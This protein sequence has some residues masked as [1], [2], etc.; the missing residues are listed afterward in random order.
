MAAARRTAGA[1]GYETER[2]ELASLLAAAYLR[3]LRQ[4][5]AKPQSQANLETHKPPLM[6]CYAPPPE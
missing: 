2:G 6:S 3:A 5:A 4:R 1:G